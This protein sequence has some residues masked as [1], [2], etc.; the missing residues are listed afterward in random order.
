MASAIINMKRNATAGE[1]LLIKALVAHPMETGL[2]P[3]ADGKV[4]PTDLIR[5]FTC[6]FETVD[7]KSTVFSANLY[8][9]IAANPYIS[10]YFK[11]S[12]SGKL[13]FTWIGDNGFNQSENVSLTVA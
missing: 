3:G 12:K 8:A 5:T 9:A 10:F 1:V 7:R 4:L 2:R 11:A 6:T 13:T